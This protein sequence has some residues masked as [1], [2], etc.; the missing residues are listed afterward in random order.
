MTDKLEDNMIKITEY[1]EHE[2]GSATLQIELSDFVKN[3][4]LELGFISLV[5][6]H[7]EDLEHTE[8]L[9]K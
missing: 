7:I 2:D 1:N 9:K 6:K 5:E 3:V 8:H 4:L